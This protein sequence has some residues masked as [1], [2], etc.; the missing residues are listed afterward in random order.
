VTKKLLAFSAAL[1]LTA[2]AQAAAPSHCIA[3]YG[4][5]K[6]KADFKHFEYVNP[7]APKGGLVKLA[8]T[9]TFDTLHPF[10]LKG[11]KAAGAKDLLFESLMVGSL[12]EPQTLYG[13]VA[14]SVTVADDGLSAEFTLRKEARWQDGTSITPD[15]VVFSFDTLKTK[16]DPTFGIVFAPIEKAEKTG[17][18]TVK[19][20]FKDAKNREIP[21]IAATVPII[22]KAYY[23][24]HDFE[25]STLEAPMGS[26]PYKVKSVEPGKSVT[27]ELD[28][29]YWG[30]NLAVNRGQY[31]FDIR[32]D[33]YR[34]ENVTLEALKAGEYDFRQEYIARN[35]ATAYDAPAVKDGRIVKRNI[36]DG[37]PQGMQGF[38][39]NT[40]KPY[41][42]DRRV[43]EAIDLTL[44]Y[45]WLNKTIFYGAYERNDSFFHNT[46]FQAKG[47]PEGKELELLKPFEK[48]L[49]PE[50]FTQPFKNPVSDGSGNNRE[51]LLKAQ[52]LLDE[53]GYPV[54]DGKRVD[55]NG[56]PLNI[57]FLL[58]QPT[59]ERVIG[60]MRKN[61]ERLGIAS[62]IRMVD[63][64]QY[65]KRTD[66]YDFDVVSIWINRG[67]FYPGNEQPALWHSSQA[68][69]KGGNNLG[70][71]K[72]KAVDALLDALINSKTE[73]EMVAA[74]R[75]LDRV[76]L[77]EHYVI[78]NWHSSSF[79]VAYWDKFEMPKTFPKYGLGFQGWWLKK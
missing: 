44:D 61:L 64:S 58:R 48:D 26:G 20:T 34:D 65:Q 56:K 67:T 47:L 15:D 57:E 29:N 76:L 13:L 31:N 54:K 2:A 43:R 24:K 28:P 78:P 22:S 71:V 72:H 79:R 19:F 7:E 75:A 77:W 63:D 40:R 23:S 17:E 70:G 45:Q 52:K 53:A 50:L 25:K 21:M 18:R 1:F 4:E 60:P 32:Y 69:V 42:S 38:I 37:R 66:E 14:E 36:P 55:A 6:Y 10:I 3:L 8:E 74:G 5:C 11:V 51:N 9:G 68:D 46:Q 30:K 41:L 33:Y 27:Y 39:Y 49:P 62:S 16:G 35:W 73:E 12:D 59:M